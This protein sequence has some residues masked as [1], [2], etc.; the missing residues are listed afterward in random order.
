MK[1]HPGSLHDGY[2]SDLRR[3]RRES[4]YRKASV[5]TKLREPKSKL[6][7]EESG[8]RV[9]STWDEYAVESIGRKTVNPRD[10]EWD[11][12]A[13]EIISDIVWSEDEGEVKTTGSRKQ[14][15]IVDSEDWD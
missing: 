8:R 10:W 4:G 7:L 2:N 6:R 15:G 14:K 3:S 13:R 5:C 1:Q 9:G 12:P 11:E